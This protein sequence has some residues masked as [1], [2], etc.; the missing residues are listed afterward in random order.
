MRPR[1]QDSQLLDEGFISN[2][3]DCGRRDL[4]KKKLIRQQICGLHLLDFL[5]LAFASGLYIFLSLWTLKLCCL[6]SAPSA[7]P[8]LLYDPL[9]PLCPHTCEKKDDHSQVTYRIV[10]GLNGLM[11][12]E[13]IP[14]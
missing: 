9:G 3:R 4:S 14:S 10:L 5:S 12:V 6:G 13:H 7:V 1:V 2:M 11:H 8:S